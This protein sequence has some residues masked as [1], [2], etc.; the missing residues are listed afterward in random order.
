MCY[1]HNRI[2]KDRKLSASLSQF[3][4]S[5][6]ASSLRMAVLFVASSLYVGVFFPKIVIGV[7][8][9]NVRTDFT[10][11]SLTAAEQF[12]RTLAQFRTKHDVV[13]AL[14]SRHFEPP[15]FHRR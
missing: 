8:A 4:F 10:T 11:R 14:S 5:I 9:V 13:V 15:I 7:Q 2:K 12:A 1:L 3:D 6:R